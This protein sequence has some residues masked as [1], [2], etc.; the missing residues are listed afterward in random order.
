MKN[1]RLFLFLF[2]S[3]AF[4][5]SFNS[6]KKSDVL[7]LFK[8]VANTEYFKNLI[9]NDGGFESAQILDI[10]SADLFAKEHIKGA[11]NIPAPNDA[12]ASSESFATQVKKAFPPNN[13]KGIFIY[14]ISA[15]KVPNNDKYVHDMIAPGH[16]ANMGFRETWLL[17]DGFDAWK[18]ENQK[19][20]D[21]YP[22]AK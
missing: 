10:R 9:L 1:V 2:M 11:I 16:V 3:V 7:G 19:D 13:G 12:T 14:G 8:N 22:I 21:A 18:K 4:A 17:K 5:S 6:C 20:P 15:G